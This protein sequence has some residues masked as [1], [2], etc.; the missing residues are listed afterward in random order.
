M[1]KLLIVA[2]LLCAWVSLLESANVKPLA[3]GVLDTVSGILGPQGDC[4]PS[5]GGAIEELC[6]VS[7]KCFDTTCTYSMSAIDSLNGAD[8]GGQVIQILPIEYCETQRMTIQDSIYLWMKGRLKANQ[9]TCLDSIRA[10][11]NSGQDTT[12]CYLSVYDQFTIADKVSMSKRAP[13]V[14]SLV[15]PVAIWKYTCE[16]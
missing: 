10:V 13:F 3:K 15:S 12:G 16:E 5:L 4:P 8:H 7:T 11:V 14:D 6:I 9:W 2:V 1:K